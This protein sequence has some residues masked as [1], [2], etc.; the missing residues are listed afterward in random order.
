MLTYLTC[1][2]YST[3][4]DIVG[5]MV[6]YSGLQR[7]DKGENHYRNVNFELDNLLYSIAHQNTFNIFLLLLQVLRND[8]LLSF[9]GSKL[10]CVLWAEFADQVA[11]YI[12]THK[13]GP[14]ILVLQFAKI[15]HKFGKFTSIMNYMHFKT[16]YET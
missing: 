9:S 10:K 5:V 14:Y 6:S 2:S 15:Q 8:I 12:D 1:C 7:I 13:D 4:S 3:I 16:P 11:H